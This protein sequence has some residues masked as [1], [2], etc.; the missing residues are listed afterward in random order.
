MN[1]TFKKIQFKQ[2]RNGYEL[3][4]IN[5]LQWDNEIS[6]LSKLKSTHKTCVGKKV[7]QANKTTRV[8]S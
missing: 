4:T 5:N 8:L 7:Y 1:P 3:S 6:T 2:H